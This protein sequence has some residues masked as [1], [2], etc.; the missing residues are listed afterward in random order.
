[1]IF[2]PKPGIKNMQLHNTRKTALLSALAVTAILLVTSATQTQAAENTGGKM[3][4]N[5]QTSANIG[6]TNNAI[7]AKFNAKTEAVGIGVFTANEHAG[8]ITN[9]NV[10][11]GNQVVGGNKGVTFFANG[12]D[13]GNR[14]NV[15]KAD[16]GSATLTKT[17]KAFN[18]TSGVVTVGNSGTTTNTH[19][20]AGAAQYGTIEGGLQH[21]NEVFG[22]T[23]LGVEIHCS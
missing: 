1:M 22:G 16:N 9:W 14:A 11:F 23:G 20:A 10:G 5:A 17:G 2:A 21:A 15:T 7:A 13:I 19:T 12:A 3:G 8:A 18:D 4:F 6:S